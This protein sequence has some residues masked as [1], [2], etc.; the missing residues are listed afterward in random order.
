MSKLEEIRRQQRDAKVHAELMS[1]QLRDA[2]DE[3]VI[4]TA[5]A[6]SDIDPEFIQAQDKWRSA[7]SAYNNALNE[8]TKLLGPISP[9]GS[10]P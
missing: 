2:H 1:R 4:A 8:Y 5:A 6:K 9:D 10:G 7:S 3:L